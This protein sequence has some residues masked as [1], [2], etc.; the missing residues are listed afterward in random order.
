MFRQLTTQSSNSLLAYLQSNLNQQNVITMEKRSGKKPSISCFSIVL[1]PLHKRVFLWS[2][3]PS[4]FLGS[5][6]A[7]DIFAF[8]SLIDTF[9]LICLFSLCCNFGKLLCYAKHFLNSWFLQS[10]SN[11][12]GDERVKQ[13]T[14]TIPKILEVSHFSNVIYIST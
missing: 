11:S 6:S 14:I 12:T 7:D 5:E 1:L 13:V 2:D 8:S 10:A 9:Y 3:I 4:C